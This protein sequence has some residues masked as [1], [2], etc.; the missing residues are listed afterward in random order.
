M[1]TTHRVWT[2]EQVLHASSE[3][4][5]CELV[6]GEL[7]M[8]TPGGFEH[9]W[10]A[11]EIGRAIAN[12][13]DQRGLGIVTGAETGFHIAHD[14]DTVRAP[15]AGFIR[16]QRV[17]AARMRGFFQGPPD[18]AVEVVSPGD[19][20]KEVLGKVHSWLDA[21]SLAVW[22]VDP[23]ARTVTLYR[24]RSDVRILQAGDEIV[25]ADLLPGFALPVAAVFPS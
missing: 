21:G 24:S 15:D 13:V 25:D 16:A 6:R 22:V 4:G 8:M 10:I 23:D 7:I 5:R 14:P 1:A 12:F 17:P 2:A 18:L 9:G 11:M 3:L 20:P 19:R